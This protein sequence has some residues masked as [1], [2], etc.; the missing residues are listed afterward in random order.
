MKGKKIGELVLDKKLFGHEINIPLLHQVTLMYQ[1]AQ[2][3]GTAS[4]KTRRYVRGGGKKPWRQKGTGRART[5]SI[6]NPLWRGGGVVFGPH[7]RDYSYSMPAKMKN[8]AIRSGLISKLTDG[9]LH[10]LDKVELKEPKTKLFQAILDSLKVKRTTLVILDKVDD[11]IKKA[12]RNIPGV[13]VRTFMT[14]NVMDVLKHK[15][16]VITET[17]L[18]SLNKRLA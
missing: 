18:K 17:A 9:K 12:S 6:R 7:P 14:F 5:G 16:L 11:N 2:R 13:S 15:E 3:Q 8:L 4:T 10:I 1:A